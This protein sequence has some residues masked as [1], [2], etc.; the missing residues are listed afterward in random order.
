[1][2]SVVFYCYCGMSI[3]VGDHMTRAEA[4]HAITRWLRRA[5]R[6]GQPVSRIGR[7]SWECESPEDAGSVSDYDGVLCAKQSRAFAY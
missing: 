4:Q 6:N 5:K 1:M 7:N 3:P 2:W